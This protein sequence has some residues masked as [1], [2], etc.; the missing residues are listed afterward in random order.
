VYFGTGRAPTSDSIAA[1][2]ASSRVSQSVTSLFCRFRN[3]R[4]AT[5]FF[6]CC[7]AFPKPLFATLLPGRSYDDRPWILLHRTELPIHLP[8]MTLLAGKRR[9][10]GDKSRMIFAN[11]K[12]GTIPKLAA[13]RKSCR[14]INSANKTKT[15]DFYP[16]ILLPDIPVTSHSN[17]SLRNAV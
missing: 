11:S 7:N 1:Y 9:Q 3:Q 13:E 16:G 10:N 2:M 12:D 5:S 8:V 17:N 4:S 6:N 14:A 15:H